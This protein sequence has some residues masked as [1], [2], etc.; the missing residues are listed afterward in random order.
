MFSPLH[1]L[2]FY[3][4]L[5]YSKEGKLVIHRIVSINIG[6][7]EKIEIKTKGDNN[8][9]EDNWVVTEEEIIGKVKFMLPYIGYPSVLV[10]DLL[11]K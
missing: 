3:D 2:Q 8:N 10:N 11:K 4:I 7:N 9:A 6:E 1:V 5:Y